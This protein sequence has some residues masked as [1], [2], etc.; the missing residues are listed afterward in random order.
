MVARLHASWR[1]APWQ[2]LQ[3]EA[4]VEQNKA[5]LKQLRRQGNEYQVGLCVHMYIFMCLG[6]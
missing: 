2:G 5:L 4:L 6:V 3:T 1:T